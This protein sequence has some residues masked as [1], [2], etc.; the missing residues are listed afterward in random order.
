MEKSST[1]YSD[2]ITR[3]FAGEA[4]PEE[5]T[6]LV[7]WVMADPSNQKLFED[8]RQTW[9][10]IEKSRIESSVDLDRDWNKLS[11]RIR[12]IEQMKSL[13]TQTSKHSFK[14]LPLDSERPSV[15]YNFYPYL[16][17]A[18]I[19]LLLLIPAWLI[20]RN[21]IAPG[22]ERLVAD[23]SVVEAMLP[24]GTSVALNAGSTLDYPTH[25]VNNQREVNLNGEAYFDVAH[26]VTKPF[27]ISNGNVR[28]KALGTA[29][30]VNT[31]INNDMMEIVLT[32]GRVAVYFQD[33][34]VLRVILEPGEKAALSVTSRNIIKSVNPDENYM[35]WKTRRINFSDQPLDVVVATLTRVYHTDIS[36]RIGELNNCRL[37][38]T[39]DHQ[40]LESVLNVLKTTLDITINNNASG[41]ELSGKGC[42]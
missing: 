19:L 7:D 30:N 28:I 9:D 12:H 24:D 34:P 15:R 8:C 26:N 39:F 21:F 13:Q 38:A 11:T 33:Q 10:H 37:T 14:V 16:K 1:Y 2:L 41:I 3:Y 22:T 35:A 29:F 6:V 40:S 4:T 17:V 5:V 20:Y 18:A 27:V 23:H 25:F 42:N 31:R 32:R 36:V